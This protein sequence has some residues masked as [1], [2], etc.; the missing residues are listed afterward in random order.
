MYATVRLLSGDATPQPLLES[1]MASEPTRFLLIDA[2][3]NSMEVSF[4]QLFATTLG[5]RASLWIVPEAAHTG[6]FH[7][8]PEEYEQR[9]GDFFKSE[10][11]GKQSGPN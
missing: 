11:V 9:G 6:T 3:D 4:N 8:Y 5:D 1:M 10:L 7:L 2:G